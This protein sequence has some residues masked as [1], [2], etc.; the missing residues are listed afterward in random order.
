MD[1]GTFMVVSEDY[2]RGILKSKSFQD[3]FHE[4][5]IHAGETGEILHIIWSN[6]PPNT[7]R[8]E[9]WQVWSEPIDGPRLR[10]IS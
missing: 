5:S 8:P 1:T 2:S 6:I 4:A 10:R 7:D 3:A 9:V